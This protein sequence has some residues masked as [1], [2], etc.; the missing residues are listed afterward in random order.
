MAPGEAA[1]SASQKQSIEGKPE[2][3]LDYVSAVPPA[4]P[5]TLATSLPPGRWLV[6]TGGTH[7][8]F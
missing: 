8:R 5:G 2:P 6:S 7:R 4:S 3:A 1:P